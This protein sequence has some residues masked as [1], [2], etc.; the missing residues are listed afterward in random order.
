MKRESAR[1]T[2]NQEEIVLAN[3]LSSIYVKQH[4]KKYNIYDYLEK[5]HPILSKEE[6]I[7]VKHVGKDSR[8][9]GDLAVYCQ[10]K[11]I[12]VETKFGKDTLANIGEDSLTEASIWEDALSWSEFREAVKMEQQVI[13]ILSPLNSEGLD[14]QKP[15]VRADFV[16]A[17][18]IKLEITK[19]TE[20]T[21]LKIIEDKS[22][23]LEIAS[24]LK[25]I[26][27]IANQN[28][29]EYVAYLSTRVINHENLKKFLSN[30][31]SGITPTKKVETT[32][33]YEL[34]Y[35]TPK[36]IIKV[37]IETY[38]AMNLD[39]FSVVYNDNS[40][41]LKAGTES[42]K[43]VFHWKNVMQG[44]QTPCLNVFKN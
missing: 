36:E 14:L 37:P 43:V 22:E 8:G 32:L 29:K 33:P 38:Q 39:Q 5:L 17:L 19:N 1:E 40:V 10:N 4:D 41:E 24:A 31:L 20:P 21:L 2:A 34:Y 28:K 12:F 18:K 6:V 44:I 16:R 9:L 11:V 15:N 25:K 7:E 23:H 27:D 26:I 30:L 3:L 35:M 13:D 42:V